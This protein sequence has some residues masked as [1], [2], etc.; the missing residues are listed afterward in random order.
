MQKM[1]LIGFQNYDETM[2]PHLK[3]VIDLLN[4]HY[5]LDYFFFHERGYF[6][7]NILKQPFNPK[8]PLRIIKSLAYTFV[9][10]V[11]LIPKKDKY[12]IVIAIDYYAYAIT[13]ILFS[14]HKEFILWSHDLI[15]RDHLIY[16]NIFVK[17]YMN[18]CAKA[19]NKNKRVIIQD[20]DRLNLLK[21][22]LDLNGS[23]L[24]PFY[25][26]VFLEN[27]NITAPRIL[28]SIER[29]RLIQSGG[30]GA[31]HFSD[32]LLE[33]YQ[34]NATKYRLYFHGFIFKEIAEYLPTCKFQPMVSSQRVKA[35]YIP[36]LI[37]HCDIGFI[38]YAQHDLN[39]YYIAKA[40][41]QLVEFLRLG[42][43]V[44]VLS[45]TNLNDFVD[46]YQIGVSIKSVNQL[47]QAIKAITKNYRYY[48][49]NCLDCF[50]RYFNHESYIAN[51]LNWL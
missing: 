49:R 14:D 18:L 29:P 25:M 13:S 35:E 46:Q 21:D 33:H 4:Q 11:R 6:I 22:S 30:I 44:I 19:L 31:Y 2:Y 8:N 9:D 42:M 38:G 3:S 37:D 28:S 45:E 10:L 15:G 7:E 43:P 40:S 16:Y 20:L 51:I 17:R 41:G 24:N 39:F 27:L 1:L 5:E 36:Q 48:S 12:D 26:P 47:N 34:T 23:E 32:Q 50:I